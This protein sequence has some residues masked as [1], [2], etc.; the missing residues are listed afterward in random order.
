M[1]IVQRVAAN[2]RSGGCVLL[3]DEA[4]VFLYVSPIRL[5]RWSV[6][7]YFKGKEIWGKLSTERSRVGFLACSGVSSGDSVLD[8]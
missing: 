8:V 5:E 2:I 6:N 7:A 3:L 4:D 1:S